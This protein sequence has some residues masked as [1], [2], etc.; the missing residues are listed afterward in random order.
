M[1]SADEFDNKIKQKI[2]LNK[3]EIKSQESQTIWS[4]FQF[5][6]LMTNDLYNY[7]PFFE[8]IIMKVFNV[9]IEENIF[10]CEL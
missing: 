2:L 3:E 6:F 8:R 1:S 7:A 5:K 4:L 10:I 9:C